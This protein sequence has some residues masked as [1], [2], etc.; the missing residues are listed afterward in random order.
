MEILGIDIGGSGVK[1]APVDISR[2]A[3]TA[4]RCRIK[5]PKPATPVAVAKVVA[6]I[7]KHFGWQGPVGCALPA[8]VKHGVALTAANIDRGWIGTHVPRLIEEHTGCRTFALNDADAAGVAEMA[9]GAGR[10]RH[11]Y[12]L[13]LTVGTGIGSAIF[14]NQT[15]VP[16]TELGHLELGGHEAE[17]YAADSARKREDLSWRDWARRFQ[18]YLEHVEFL[19]APDLIIVGGGISRPKK[20]AKFADQL[21][22]QAELVPARLQNEAGI[23]GAAYSARILH[24]PEVAV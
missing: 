15:L 14:I 8:R 10:D 20:W 24:Q 23:I 9:F 6:R 5:T 3:L 7:V 16:N 21:E 18:R 1:G 19:F 11:D 2:G 17:V 12:V 4:E 22:T 13:V